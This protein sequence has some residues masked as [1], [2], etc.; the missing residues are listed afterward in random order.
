MD[1]SI[2]NPSVLYNIC[3][4]WSSFAVLLPWSLPWDMSWFWWQIWFCTTQYC[5]HV[6][7][8]SLNFSLLL[9]LQLQVLSKKCLLHP[10]T[11]N[12]LLFFTH[13]WIWNQYYSRV[14]SRHE[15]I[16]RLFSMASLQSNYKNIY[17][18]FPGFRAWVGRRPRRLPKKLILE[19]YLLRRA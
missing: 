11:T 4:L 9:Q 18:W 19:Q 17:F 2:Q 1:N 6:L 15:K 16:T 13:I 7:V 3:N 10:P 8:F 12:P 14:E 5:P